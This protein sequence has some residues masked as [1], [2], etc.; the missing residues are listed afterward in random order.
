MFD[1]GYLEILIILIIA[2]MVIGPARM[3]EVARKIGQFSGKA[4][5]F[6][7]SMKEDSEI[8]SVIKEVKD[9]MNIEEEKKQLQEI[10]SSLQ[11]DMQSMHKEWGVDEE[12][13]RPS[14]GNQEGKQ[15]A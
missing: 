4:K 1:I 15:V 8:S 12:L 10:S 11:E 13:N 6:M 14:F 7:N 5:R 9:S 3:P 2:L